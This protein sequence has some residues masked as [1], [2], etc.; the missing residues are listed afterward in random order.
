MATGAGKTF[1]AVTETY[2]LHNDASCADTVVAG[3][4]VQFA[5]SVG[6]GDHQGVS[7]C[8]DVLTLGDA[9]RIERPRSA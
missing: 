2:R 6:V 8:P 4:P 1:T 3:S 9:N 7:Y 5:D